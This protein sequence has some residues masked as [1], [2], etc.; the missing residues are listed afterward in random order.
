MKKRLSQVFIFFLLLFTSSSLFGMVLGD[1][2]S[3]ANINILD[4]L[5]TAQYAININPPGFILA[6]ADVDGN[7]IIN[8]VDALIIAQYSVGLITVFPADRN[9]LDPKYKVLLVPIVDETIVP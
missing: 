8:I 4:A 2:N 3:D 6:N 7:N 1:V 9:V 5:M